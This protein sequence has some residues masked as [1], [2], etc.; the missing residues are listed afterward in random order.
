LNRLA[1]TGSSSSGAALLPDGT[2]EQVESLDPV[3]AQVG[4]G[5][6]SA[7]GRQSIGER[8]I[9]VDGANGGGECSWIAGIDR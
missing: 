1:R 6:R 7:R 4:G 3:L 5:E 9:L 2:Q 8:A